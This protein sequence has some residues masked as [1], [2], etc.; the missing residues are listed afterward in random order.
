MVLGTICG[1]A[2]GVAMPCFMLLFGNIIDEIGK[3]Q[4]SFQDAINKLAMAMAILGAL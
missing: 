4:G 3:G 2:T 1:V